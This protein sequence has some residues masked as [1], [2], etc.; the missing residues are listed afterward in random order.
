MLTFGVDFWCVYNLEFEVELLQSNFWGSKAS[1]NN[2]M[3]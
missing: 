3:H 1:T 2:G